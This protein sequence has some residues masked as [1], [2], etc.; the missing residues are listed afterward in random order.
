[1]ISIFNYAFAGF[2][3]F[4]PVAYSSFASAQV[5]VSR[6][7]AAQPGSAVTSSAS[8]AAVRAA[9]NA[10]AGSNIAI[11]I[12]DPSGAPKLIFVPDGTAGQMGDLARRKANTALRFARPSSETRDLAKGDQQLA[13]KIS[14]DASLAAFGGGLYL[15]KEG[16]S[17]GALAVAG[18]KAQADDERCAAA[19]VAALGTQVHDLAK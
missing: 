9:L 3:L 12:I 19:G 4:G 17:L 11:A 15:S 1:M 2:A 10:C 7:E 16:R 5:P 18:A 13:A 6:P 14:G 8:M